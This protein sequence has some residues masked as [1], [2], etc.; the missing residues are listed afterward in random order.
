[1]N[2]NSNSNR[3]P[4]KFRGQ[5]N[6]FGGIL[7]N[8]AN[9]INTSRSSIVCVLLTRTRNF[10][11]RLARHRPV[12]G[13]TRLTRT[14]PLPNFRK[15]VR[16]INLSKFC[17]SGFSLQSRSLSMN[18]GTKGRTTTTSNRGGYISKLKVLTRG[19]RTSN[20]LSNSCIKVVRK[21]SG[22][23]TLFFKRLANV[24]VNVIMNFTMGRRFTTTDLRHI[25]LRRKHN[26][27]RRGGN[28]D[29]RLFNP[30]NRPLNVISYQE[31]GRPLN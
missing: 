18:N 2:F 31:D 23:R 21:V 10:F 22:N 27:K 15:L 7:G 1:M 8:N 29:A 20:T 26:N 12:N 24:N 25:R 4:N 9:I 16:N 11:T 14:C 6:I 28:T 5:T 19:F 13:R 30:R 3:N 17:A